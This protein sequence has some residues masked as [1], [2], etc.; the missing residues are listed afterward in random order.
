ML[1][2]STFCTSVCP[3]SVRRGTGTHCGMVV[4]RARRQQVGITLGIPFLL[5]ADTDLFFLLLF[6]CKFLLRK[7]GA[8]SVTEKVKKKSIRDM[9]KTMFS[10]EQEWANI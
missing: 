7:T 1:A 8:V 9:A 2:S 10:L 3:I 4:L 6:F 5:S